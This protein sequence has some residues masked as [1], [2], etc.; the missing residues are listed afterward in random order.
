MQQYVT[1]KLASNHHLV[2][3]KGKA[4]VMLELVSE[5]QHLRDNMFLPR[6][7]LQHPDHLPK[8][9]KFEAKTIKFVF[10]ENGLDKMV[11]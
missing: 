2:V 6:G 1:Q 10:V 5:L 3:Q 9:Y 8:M 7:K 11:Y 4:D